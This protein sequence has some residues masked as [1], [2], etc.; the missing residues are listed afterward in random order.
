MRA[1]RKQRETLP[2]RRFDAVILDLD[3]VLTRDGIDTDASARRF[4]EALRR[5][6]F[7]TAIV[8]SS[9]N[10]VPALKAAGALGLFDAKIGGEDVANRG[11]AGKPAPDRFLAAAAALGVPAARS[12][13]VGD[14]V[15]GVAA[16]R[17]GG[18]GAV[19]GVDRGAKAEALR[20]HG[21]DIVV[22]D[23]SEIDIAANPGG[24][25]QRL[26]PEAIEPLSRRIGAKQPA[27]F[28]DF[29]GTLTPIVDRPEDA[30]LSA[31]MREI[32]RRIATFHRVAIVSGRDLTDIKTRV[33]L[34]RLVYAGSHGFDIALPDGRG[35][36]PAAARAAL[37]ALDSA[38]RALARALGGV[39]GVLVE[40]KRFAI[41]VHYRLAAADAVDGIERI[42]DRVRARHD[43]LRKRGGKKIFELMPD[44]E[45]DKGR[46]VLWL[47]DVLQLDPA[48]Q[49]PIYIGDD[50]TDED[51]F[52]ALAG[53]GLG[54]VVDPSERGTAATFKLDDT[55][56][57]QTL[58]DG[59]SKA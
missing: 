37:P 50:I 16:G 55:D 33:G 17:A 22:K 45:W 26:E 9:T 34:E 43:C 24:A 31:P 40:R 36:S 30:V 19:I 44:I 59:F 57:V 4:V 15:S 2:R 28:L 25:A 8:S 12:V 18:F 53:R 35:V 29:D 3:G 6:G 20:A 54:I 38:E 49:I 23:L 1:E 11:L 32:L 14:T 51:A 13:V 46:A 41:A 56:A 52:A 21:A 48:K 42:V 47:L 5:A 7:K 58:L 27:W 10:C 39:D